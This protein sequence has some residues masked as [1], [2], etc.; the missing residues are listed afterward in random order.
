MKKRDSQVD[1]S[2]FL[3]HGVMHLKPLFTL[4]DHICYKLS[5]QTSRWIRLD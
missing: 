4:N 1:V 5:V 2:T 3:L